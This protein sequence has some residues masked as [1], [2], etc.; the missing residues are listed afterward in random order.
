MRRRVRIGRCVAVLAC[1]SLVVAGCGGGDGDDDGGDGAAASTT[2][3]AVSTDLEVLESSADGLQAAGLDALVGGTYVLSGTRVAVAAPASAP[4]PVDPAAAPVAAGAPPTSTFGATAGGYP[5]V[6]VQADAAG[7]VT[8][9]LAG[10]LEGA[11]GDFDLVISGINDGPLLGPLAGFDADIAAAQAAAAAGIPALVVAVGLDEVPPDYQ[12][13]V[14]QV[15]VWL[16]EHRDALLSGDEPAQ[17]TVLNV[18]SCGFVQ[19]RGVVQVPVATDEG[20]R[21][22]NA[23]DCTS[24]A[25]A[26]ADDIAAFT[27]GY[28]TRTVLAAPPAGG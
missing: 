24:T 22:V 3:S 14:S 12:A 11:P 9:A 8:A 4:A 13:A 6:S 17:V 26:P 15:V 19:V 16:D 20:G 21:D 28:A 5:G 25:E 7:T 2:T 27:T 23:V 10:Q 18:P 1:A